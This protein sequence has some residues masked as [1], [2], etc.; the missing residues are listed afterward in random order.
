MNT[1][2]S[3]SFIL[4]FLI[5]SNFIYSQEE[6]N[7]GTCETSIATGV[8]DFFQKYFKCV[9]IRM[10]ESGDYVN[11]YYNGLPPY[12][13]WYYPP[14]NSNNI[15]WENQGEDCPNNN[16]CNNGECVGSEESCYFQIP[17]S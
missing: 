15:N 17:G 7:L 8:P 2:K 1:F 14:D 5:I 10:S 11:L 3:H 6:Y 13:S 12:N 16:P 4:F 9:T